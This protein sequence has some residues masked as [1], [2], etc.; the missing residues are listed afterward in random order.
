[1]VAGWFQ[2]VTIVVRGSRH[3]VLGVKSTGHPPN[4]LSAQLWGGNF[5][6]DEWLKRNTLLPTKDVLGIT[7]RDRARDN[8]LVGND[9]VGRV[10]FGTHG[11]A[12]G[13]TTPQGAAPRPARNNVVVAH[14]FRGSGVGWQD[15]SAEEGTTWSIDNIY[16]G[17]AGMP[18][19]IPAPPAARA[20]ALAET[21]LKAP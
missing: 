20:I 19:G 10:E 3:T 14:T 5:D 1:V 15:A 2:S 16:D 12:E 21:G 11:K 7:P 8:L 9:F 18:G 17:S 4:G 6:R 13:T